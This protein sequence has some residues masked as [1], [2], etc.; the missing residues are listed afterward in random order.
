MTT[1]EPIEYG[2]VTALRRHGRGTPLVIVPGVMADAAGW[3]PVGNAIAATNP[4]VIVNR[5]GRTPSRDLGQDYGIPVEIDDLSTLLSDIGE[6]VH[7]FGWSYGALI[8]TEAAALGL[9]VRSLMAYEPVSR[10]FVPETIKPIRDALA[11]GDAGRAV[12]IINIDVSGFDAA[13]VATLR[14]TAAWET[15][16]RL[17]RPLAEELAAIDRFEPS[18]ERYAKIDANINL[19]L[20]QLNE[21]KAPYGEAFD[22]FAGAMPQARIDRLA[23]QGHLAHVE[24]PAA[25]ARCISMALARTERLPTDDV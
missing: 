4:V 21:G 10:P 14:Q 24:N 12:E 7:L 5:R 16:C 15:L 19:I 1:Y 18:Y 23:G 6:P 8:A 20:G 3:L 22:R 13:Y 2:S 9:P 25:L 11:R 17:S